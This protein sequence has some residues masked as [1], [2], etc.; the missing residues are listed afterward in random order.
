MRNPADFALLP[1]KFA[2]AGVRLV[3]I[4]AFPASK[5]DGA[6]FKMEGT[7]VIGISGRGQRL[8]KVLF[9]ILHECAH[10][11]LGHTEHGP[12][13]DID[14]PHGKEREDQANE[15]AANWALNTPLPPLPDR[16]TQSWL[17]HVAQ[18]AS[19]HPVVVVGRLQHDRKLSWRSALVKD[20]P[21][22]TE[23]LQAW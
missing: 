11:A 6:S 19:V 1:T 12:I 4:D 23:F 18:Q 8:D 22:V 3:H 9:T 2:E 15:T 16:I 17:T 7:P 14:S 20:A 13:I 21:N 10:V 5:I